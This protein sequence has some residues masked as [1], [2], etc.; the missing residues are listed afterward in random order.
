M[1]QESHIRRSSVHPTE[2]IYNKSKKKKPVFRTQLKDVEV[3]EYDRTH[4]ECLLTPIN[5]PTMKVEWLR[6]GQPLPYG[7]F[8]IFLPYLK[9]YMCV[10]LYAHKCIGIFVITYHIYS[11]NV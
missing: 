9:L 7:I 6:N 1:K 2:I 3:A 10:Y 4:L 5:D 11:H 8:F